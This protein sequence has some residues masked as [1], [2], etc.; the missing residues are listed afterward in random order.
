MKI[1]IVGAGLT[2]LTAGFRLSQVGHLVTVFEKKDY[3]GGLASGFKKGD[4][5]W[6]LENFF[7]HLFTSD[8]E[9]KRL[10]RELG[11]GNKLFYVRPRSSIYRNGQ[12]S[13]F[14]SAA[15]VIFFPHLSFGEKLRVGLI[16]AYLKLTGSWQGLEKIVASKW[17]KKY[18]GQSAYR[19][20]WEPLIRAKFGQQAENVSMA[21]FWSRIKKRSAK[22]GYLR[23]GFQE[24]V[25]RLAD[26]IRANKGEIRLG[27]EVKSLKDLKKF[28]KIIVTT[29]IEVFF[30]T[31]IP[32]MLGALNLILILEQQFLVDGTYWLNINEDNFP[33][34]AVV[35]HTN[36]VDKKYYQ[37]SQIL[38][39]GGYYPADHRYFKM[40]GNQILEEF[41]PYLKKI[42]PDFNRSSVMAYE[43][44]VDRFAQPVVPINYS[45]IIPT[46][47]T[48][49]NNV[50]L[51]NM[52][53]VYPWD[54]GMNYAI[55][56]GENVARFVANESKQKKKI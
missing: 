1:A 25:D 14:D 11:L 38:Y 36:F 23:G 24:M 16:T 41:L 50:Y 32:K 54:R 5:Q 42:K 40:T 4:W 6:S 13:Q 48:K 39:V 49:M 56:M 53:M 44:R 8:N 55:E 31:R 10:I 26:R 17:L 29:P 18:Y 34:V 19:V 30:K 15:S 43:L 46:L 9:A 3:L 12:I 45:K 37:N 52:Q 2:G 28:D 20:L 47:R 27:Q 33:F 35:E 51:A 22:L 7:H 21:W